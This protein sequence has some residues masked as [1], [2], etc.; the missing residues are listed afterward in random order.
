MTQDSSQA[1]Q[2]YPPQ[3]PFEEDTISL[4]D[5][6]LVLVKHLKF[7]I[8]TPTVFCIITI[9]YALFFTS[10]VY[11]STATFMSSGGVHQ[12]ANHYHLDKPFSKNM[13]KGMFASSGEFSL[14][15]LAEKN[16]KPWEFTP[17][18]AIC[19]CVS[20]VKSGY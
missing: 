15:S 20:W 8:I 5:I 12:D 9:I 13:I 7:I 3:Y 17:P 4:I 1:S 16:D 14:Y 18:A 6:L 10:P 11:V 2:P 19:L